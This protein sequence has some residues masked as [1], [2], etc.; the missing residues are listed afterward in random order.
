MYSSLKFKMYLDK[1]IGK[2]PLITLSPKN[3]MSPANFE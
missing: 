1:K 2:K 3:I